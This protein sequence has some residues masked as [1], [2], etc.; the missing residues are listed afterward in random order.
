[1]LDFVQ[2]TEFPSQTSRLHA[3]RIKVRDFE[4]SITI[5]LLVQILPNP[6]KG[7]VALHWHFHCHHII[8]IKAKVRLT[9]LNDGRSFQ[10]FRVINFGRTDFNS[11][12]S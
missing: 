6:L 5:E 8:L 4:H 9:K 11:H 2:A 3:V 10:A 7:Q 12:K 1:M